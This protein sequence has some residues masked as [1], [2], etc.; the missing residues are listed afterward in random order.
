MAD[1]RALVPAVVEAATRAPS[2]HNTQPWRF[3]AHD[4]VVELWDDPARGLPVLDP[5]GRARLISCGAALALAEV[6]AAG[7]G[8][9]T[10]TTLLPDGE[11]PEHLADLQLGAQHAPDDAQ[12]ALAAAIGRRH[13]ERGAFDESTD[14]PPETVRAL[15]EAVQSN[16]CWLRVVESPDDA[17]AVTVLLAR[18]DD[19]Q[20]RDPAYRDELRQW[21]GREPDS[22]D[23][24]PVS[25]VPSEA[26]AERGSSYRLRDFDADREDQGPQWA[27]E[28]PR[29]EHPLVV[30][31][32]TAADD[33]AAW[34]AAGQALGRLLLTATTRGLAASPMTQALEVQDTRARLARDLGLVGHPQV[35]LRLGLAAPGSTAAVGHANRRSVAEVLETR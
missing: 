15:A 1:V 25:A 14:L 18:A 8:V 28:P 6:A 21:T 22:P 10:R 33:A 16:G 13:T 24:I 31:I 27:G 17:A 32:G 30:V 19:V 23:G 5:D 26:P 4:D 9:T 20:S 12:L 11:A 34:L 29:A 35:V 2:V 7:L 3:V